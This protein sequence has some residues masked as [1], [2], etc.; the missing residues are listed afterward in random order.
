MFS[1]EDP[2]ACEAGLLEF[3]AVCCEFASAYCASACLSRGGAGVFFFGGLC[4]SRNLGLSR[5][6]TGERDWEFRCFPEKKGKQQKAK[7]KSTSS[8]FSCIFSV[9]GEFLMNL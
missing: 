5:T 8:I 2:P 6:G 4:L 3:T 7:G 1:S 9:Y